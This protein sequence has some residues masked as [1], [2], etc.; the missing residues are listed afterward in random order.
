MPLTKKIKRVNAKPNNGQLYQDF[1]SGTIFQAF[2]D[3]YREYYRAEGFTAP[4][5]GTVNISG[6]DANPPDYVI[7]ARI[8]LAN[9]LADYL[10]VEGSQGKSRSYKE[11][12]KSVEIKGLSP[13]QSATGSGF[14]SLNLFRRA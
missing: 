7:T 6:S 1:A 11:G 13:D 2:D 8:L 3:E 12:I 4:P 5:S 10:S 14:Y 9:D